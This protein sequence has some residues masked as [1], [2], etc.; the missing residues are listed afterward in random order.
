MSGLL[1]ESRFENEYLQYFL[2]TELYGK[3]SDTNNSKPVPRHISRY[4][5]REHS[6]QSRHTYCLLSCSWPAN[7]QCP[8]RN[9]ANNTLICPDNYEHRIAW[10]LSDVSTR[11]ES[12]NAGFTPV[13]Y[14]HVA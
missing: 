14:M 5:L 7:T 4:L 1:G 2:I 10:K 9:S 12:L 13:A 8:S 11:D 6:L 3:Y